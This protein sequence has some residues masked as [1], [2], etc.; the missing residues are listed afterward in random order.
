MFLSLSIIYNKNEKPNNEDIFIEMLQYTKPTPTNENHN[1][2]NDIIIEKMEP[3]LNGEKDTNS[4]FD[5]KT[6][7]K[8]EG[9]L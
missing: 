8:L 5:E 4:V 3:V 9:L 7:K 1:K 2:I 6:I